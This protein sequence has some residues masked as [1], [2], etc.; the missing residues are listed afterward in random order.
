[1]L[2]T[3]AQHIAQAKELDERLKQARKIP[4]AND[5]SSTNYARVREIEADRQYYATMALVWAQ[6]GP[7]A[8]QP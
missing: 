7:I 1:M 5:A 2:T 3:T 6:L 8:L 4:G